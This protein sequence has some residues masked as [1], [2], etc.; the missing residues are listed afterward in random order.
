MG[1]K[2]RE[3]RDSIRVMQHGELLH[4]CD[5][6]RWYGDQEQPPSVDGPI[7]SFG[8]RS[9]SKGVK[10]NHRPRR[11][12]ARRSV[13]DQCLAAR[14]RRAFAPPKR[15]D[16]KAERMAHQRCRQLVEGGYGQI[17]PDEHGGFPG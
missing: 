3:R 9:E 8:I 12:P 4:N 14:E 5:H 11:K 7:W 15:P 6:R 2:Y 16:T 10:G 17:T 1:C 13:E